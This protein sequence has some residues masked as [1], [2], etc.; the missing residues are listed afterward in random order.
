MAETDMVESW[1][2]GKLP[3]V[4]TWVDCH[5]TKTGWSGQRKSDGAVIDITY[6]PSASAAG[7]PTIAR[8]PSDKDWGVLHDKDGRILGAI[9]IEKRARHVRRRAKAVAAAAR[10]RRRPAAR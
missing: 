4:E 6:D 5:H 3:V 8:M 9:R 10:S 7:P 1:M 2:Y